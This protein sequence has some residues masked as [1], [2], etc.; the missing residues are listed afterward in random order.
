MYLPND[1]QLVIVIMVSYLLRLMHTNYELLAKE[2][3]QSDCALQVLQVFQVL[4]P[5]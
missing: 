3:L 5:E 2:R 4:H 1:R